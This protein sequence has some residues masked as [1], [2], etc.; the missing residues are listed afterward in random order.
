[1]DRQANPMTA[2][3]WMQLK[4][5]FTAAQ[6]KPPQ[7]RAAI[8]SSLAQ[9]D[10][11]LELAVGDLLAADES[12][13]TFLQ[14][15]VPDQHS[16]VLAAGERLGPYQITG[17]L[18]EG[19]MGKVYRASDT[20]LGRPVAIK[21][22]IKQFDKRFERE[23]RA[24]SALN[25]PN[26]CTL[27]DVG[28]NYLVTELVEG[29]TLR[30]WLKRAP[31]LERRVETAR[32]VLEALR[33]AHG[34]GIIHRDLK[35]QNIMVRLDGYVK[36][37]DF[38]LAKQMP[39]AHSLQ[40]E[41][42]AATD[43]SIPGQMLGTIAYM[44]PEQIQGQPVD[45]RSDLFAFGI[46][47][48]EMLTGH[49]PWPRKL[50]VETLHAILHDDPPAIS[51]AAP[52][53]AEL[54]P[55]VSKLL[56]KNPAQRFPSAEA[57]LEALHS[58]TTTQA[59]F[60]PPPTAAEGK[61]PSTTSHKWIYVSAILLVVAV[62]AG[63]YLFISHRRKVLTANDTV[64]LA[65]FV[66]STGDP[67]FD[68]TLRQGL[69]VQ[70]E[71]SPF[72]SIV[73][74]QGIQQTLQLMDQKPDARLAPDVARELCQRAGAAAV[75][76][77]SIA[78]IGTQY[79]LT[80]K[81]VN[82]VTGETLASAEA[83]ASD[84]NHVLDALGETA[85]DIRSKLGES[86]STVQKFDTP[87]AQATT[88]SLEAL[89]ALSSGFKV[90][91]TAGS[92]EALPFYKHAI[93]LD[94]KF[95]LAYAWTGRLYGDIGQS[96][97]AA[98]YTQKAYELR[99]RTSE[100]EK[101]FVSASFHVVVTGNMEKAQ[102]TCA[103]WIQAY[104]R[105]VFPHSLL[106]G[107]I[108]PVS[109]QYEKAIEEGRQAVLLD[110]DFRHAYSTVMFSLIALNRLDEARATYEQALQR[111]LDFP[112][113]SIPL[114]QIAFLRNDLVGMAHQVAKSVGK[115]G[116]EDEILGMEADT[117]AYSGRLKE[118]QEFSRRAMDSAKRGDER[119]MAATYSAASALREALFGN[120]SEARRRVTLAME[121]IPGRDMQY[122]S[123]LA[124]A[125]AGED[126]RAQALADDLDKKFPEDTIVQFNYLPTLRAK[127]AV[128][129]GKALDAIEG[130]KIAAPYELGVS[131]ANFVGV[132]LY[133][134]FV[135]GEAWLAA[136]R[137]NEA[138]AEFQKI[139]DQRSDVLNEPIGV[140]AHLG[141][142]RA[143]RLQG[144]SIKARAA[145]QQFLTLWKDA[146]P[147]I[148][149][150]IAAKSEYAEL[151]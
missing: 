84:K 101:Y 70:L 41:N 103:L 128:N 108:Y 9:G 12:A 10:G 38:G 81:A 94:P 87:L 110:P 104:P 86:L 37:L 76:D 21:I 136:R 33:A 68:G 125:N 147:D 102:Q 49:H 78:Q 65:D 80:V 53:G 115:P 43:L 31:A 96:A 55:I 120:R 114:Y 90:L 129:R 7:E 1:M 71:Q 54:G 62:A 61:T 146:D 29:E 127:R 73:S 51:V 8:V 117:A 18:G 23:A 40:N 11:D 145:Y 144:D 6:G 57:V 66:N 3:R 63:A 130:L 92:A 118:A 141:L 47:L 135:R 28:P 99:D 60:A 17:L 97:M 14:T 149:V 91:N 150:L 67:V 148:P 93:E 126:A 138:A 30:D 133:P 112:L 151:Q 19:G 24:I 58:S 85:S 64:V 36:V 106:A 32:Q 35:P 137:G 72:L 2:E 39:F 109:G 44:S 59:S 116:I 5:I 4:T 134:A 131:T 139:I 16:P 122:V 142:A 95:A 119:E 143:Y 77:G 26:I 123:A 74:D 82:C 107:I 34:A 48:F 56:R 25:H 13:G 140:L 75:L 83:Q 22:S 42:V 88:S 98:D 100:A 15:P 113:Y 132:T 121:R 52:S 124:L 111:K 89:K 20:R 27:Y 46:I 105:V 50:G 69:S 45:Q 79:L